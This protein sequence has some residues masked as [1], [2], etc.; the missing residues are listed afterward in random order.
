MR[1]IAFDVR[2]DERDEFERQAARADVDELVCREE[3]L[4]ASNA[5][6]VRGFDAALILGMVSYDEVLL[7]ELAARGLR[8]L[9]TRTIGTDHIDLAAAER[10]GISVSNTSYAPD[11]VAD[12]TLMLMLVALRKYKP[13]VYRQNVNDFSLPGLM[14][15]TL[16]SLTVGI[17]GTG[18]IGCAVAR[19][20]GGFGSTVIGF[21]P[22]QSEAFLS[23]G[24]YVTLEELYRRS[25]VITFHVPAT[26]E[27]DRMVRDE[28]LATMR[29]GVVLVNTARASLMDVDT[30]VRGVETGKIGA[31]AMDVFAGEDEIYHASRVND[32]I[33][34]RDMAYLRQFPNT[35]LTQHVAFYTREAVNEMVAHA[36]DAALRCAGRDGEARE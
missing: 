7:A 25:D 11:S 33:A 30:L 20:L 28:T 6:D 5:D 10:L 8:V 29:D 32:I 24:T 9:V 13:M 36:V 17:V 19:R 2:P 18:R 35:V 26:P 14:G 22:H 21:D 27:N 23:L 31:L 12:F 3:P 1:I 34:N 15:R 4:T 16:G